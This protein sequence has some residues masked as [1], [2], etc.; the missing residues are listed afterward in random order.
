MYIYKHNDWPNF[1]WKNEAIMPVLLSVRHRQGRLIGRMEGLGF[2]LQNEV[3]L[4]TMTLEVIKTSEIEGEIL[5]VDQVRSSIARRMGMDIAGLVPSDRNVDG[6]V[7]M[8]LDATQ[9]FDQPLTQDRLFDWHAALFPTGR[10]GMQKLTVGAWRSSANEPMQVVSGPMGREKVH[11]EAPSSERLQKEMDRFL[12]W[13]NASADIDPVLKAALAHLWFATI[14]PFEDGNGRIARTIADM[15]LSRADGVLQRFYSMSAQIRIERKA[16][17]DILEATQRGSL[18]ITQWL[19][20]FLACFSKALDAAELTLSSVLR[21]AKAWEI[22]SDK[23]INERQKLMINK[24]LDGFEGK[25]T[26]AKWAKIVKSSHDTA[27]RDIQNLVEK[28]VLIKEEA[29]G[30]STSYNLVE[31]FL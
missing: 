11:F 14:H 17:Y 10:N 2:S 13:F 7:E 19:E 4:Q 8:M 20:W 5:D 24:L 27:L 22:L 25:L 3:M 26:T 29:G 30:R 21:K 28:Q 16:Y 9:N 1:T 18:D 15:Q 6:V 12:E 31:A 23:K